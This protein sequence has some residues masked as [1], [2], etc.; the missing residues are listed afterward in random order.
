MADK[1]LTLQD[2]GDRYSISRERIRQIQEK[3]TKNITK[4]L[5]DNIPGFE[6]QY[7]DFLK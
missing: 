3:I 2:L 7:S 5:K 6:E 1:P 4:W